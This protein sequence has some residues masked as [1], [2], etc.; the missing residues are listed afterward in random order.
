MA[1]TRGSGMSTL[2]G[3]GTAADTGSA[4]GTPGTAGTNVSGAADLPA[5]GA[6]G[7]AAGRPA[8]GAAEG[9]ASGTA[10]GSAML[11]VTGLTVAYGEH[12]A[13][14]DLSLTADDG[15]VLCVL[16][17]SGCGKSTLLRSI[18]GLEP[19]VSGR[20]A[21]AGA[22]VTDLRPDARHVGLMF[23]EHALFPHRTVG[24]NVAFGPR[25]R[26]ASAAAIRQ[27]VGDALDLVD[28]A[29]FDDRRVAELSGGEQQRVALARAIAPRPRL[30]M[31]DEPLGSLDRA[32][33]DRLLEDLPRLFD[34]IGTTVVYVTHDQDEA[35]TLADRVALLRD[36]RLA[37]V[38]SPEAVWRQ[39]ADSFVARFVGHDPILPATVRREVADTAL[40][41]VPAPHL[42]DGA[43]EVVVLPAAVTLVPA[44]AGVTTPTLPGDGTGSD[45][46]TGPD[47]GV[48]LLD[49]TVR[50]RRFAGDHRVLRAVTT[51]GVELDVRLWQ[52]GGPEQGAAVTLTFDPTATIVLPATHGMAGGTTE[53][54]DPHD[55]RRNS[56]NTLG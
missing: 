4:P 39:P 5:T 23:Q 41:A 18:A 36:G 2:K 47:T 32:L 56:P 17:P 12:V 27:A 33:R 55:D 50:T 21:I 1:T 14:K 42:P 9:S 10:E 37:Q 53:T 44:E 31:L 48:R 3:T 35:L 25:M 15:E 30:L 8:A 38:G 34:A 19:P 6:A 24:E 7:R 28:L 40:G 13:V 16:G 54:D 51:A 20:V 29:G 26:G 46:T 49:A 45:G 22:D 43:A 52:D 11:E